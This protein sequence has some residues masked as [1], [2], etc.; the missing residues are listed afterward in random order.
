MDSRTASLI[1]SAIGNDGPGYP[2]QVLYVEDSPISREV[3]RT[4][5][6]REGHAVACAEDGER[7]M[8]LLSTSAETI[9]VVI[10]DH[11][12]PHINGLGVVKYLRQIA[13]AGAVVV[14]SATL[15][16]KIAAEY[17]DLGVRHFLPKPTNASALIAIV[18]AACVDG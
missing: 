16:E 12:M 6:T 11:E 9:D 1:R 3:V 13:F 5:L 8:L 4:I 2:L 7:G 15:D 18:N 14:H 17:G 10:V